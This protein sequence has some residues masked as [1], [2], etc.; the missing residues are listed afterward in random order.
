M[1]KRTRIVIIQLLC[2]IS[3]VITIFSI[4]STYAKYYEKM[5]TTYATTIKKWM[6]QVNEK[7]ILE[8]EQMSTI[9]EPI[10][11][12]DSNINDNVL[13]PGRQG[14]FDLDVDYTYVD[15]SFMMKFELEQQNQTKLSDF[16]VIGYSVFENEVEGTITE[17]TDISQIINL[18]EET[19]KHKHIRIYFRWNDDEDNQMDDAA[20]TT[21][22]GETQQGKDNTVLR[23]LVK[24]NFTQL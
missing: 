1:R 22:K 6:I 19:E 17:T 20:D 18:E 3:L 21:F 16:E 7:D 4:R 24:V 9:M 11:P 10:F 8:E 14:Y 15:V 23:Y 2:L 5:N 13:V 12:Q